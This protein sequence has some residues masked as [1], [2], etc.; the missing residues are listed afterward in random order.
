[1]NRVPCD[2]TQAAKILRLNK[3]KSVRNEAAGEVFEE[4]IS[5]EWV[6]ETRQDLDKRKGAGGN[7]TLSQSMGQFTGM[8]RVRW[9]ALGKP[10]WLSCECWTT[11]TF[12]V[13]E[14]SR[15][16]I[17]GNQGTPAQSRGYC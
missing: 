9:K 1:M 15:D 7:P 17:C 5:F 12:K 11:W 16:L 4:L 10:R 2:G 14:Q 13:K 8:C 6:L 3:E